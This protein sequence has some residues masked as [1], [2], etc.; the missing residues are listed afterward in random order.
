MSGK[1]APG[2]LIRCSASQD[3]AAKEG[4]RRIVPSQ[5][6]EGWWLLP[7]GALVSLACQQAFRASGRS[8]P[9]NGGDVARGA[10]LRA[11]KEACR[12]AWEDG[13]NKVRQL[14]SKEP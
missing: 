5:R 6:A 9:L 11:G 4:M 14:T 1:L 13:H 10:T 8:R 7:D 2:D 3:S 12:D